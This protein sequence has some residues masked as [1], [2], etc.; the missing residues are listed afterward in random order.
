MRKTNPISGRCGRHETPHYS[1]IPPFQSPADRTKQTRFGG[2]CRAKQSQF[3]P[4]RWPRHPTIPVMRK[5]NPIS[6]SGSAGA[7]GPRYK[8]SQFAAGRTPHHSI[9]PVFQAD[10][11]GVKQTQFPAGRA[12]R[13]T[14][15][16]CTKRIQFPGIEPKRW[17][18]IRHHRSA[19]PSRR[20]QDR[21]CDP[22]G[23]D[24]VAQARVEGVSPLRVA[25]ILPAIR[26]RDALDTK[27]Q[28]QDA[29]AT[30]PRNTG[31]APPVAAAVDRAGGGPY[32]SGC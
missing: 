10:P 18:G 1:T 5:T 15:G 25:G 30:R 32:D 13:A 27:E 24:A 14:R 20:V 9:I 11:D 6:G 7:R 29:L 21:S 17:C 31:H 26:G 8:Q 3:W 16:E 4:S 19:A 22:R 23:S 28:G 2:T 12:G